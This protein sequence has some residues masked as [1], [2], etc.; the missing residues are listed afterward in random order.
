MQGETERQD[1]GSEECAFAFSKYFL[2]QLLHLT[3][4]LKMTNQGGAAVRCMW[5]F[6]TII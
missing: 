6:S 2:R 3:E 5:G 4:L 1:E